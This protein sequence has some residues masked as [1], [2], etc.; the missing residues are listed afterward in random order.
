MR[1]LLLTLVLAVP[2]AASA[3]DWSKFI[4]HG[5]DTASIVKPAKASPA[6]VSHGKPAPAKKTPSAKATAR[7]AKK[8]P[9]K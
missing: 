8:T 4:D 3:E 7:A 2:S 9:R 6:A 1:A 5:D